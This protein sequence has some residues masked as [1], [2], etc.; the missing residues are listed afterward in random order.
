MT[1]GSRCFRIAVPDTRLL[2]V[3]VT[4]VHSENDAGEICRSTEPFGSDLDI[5]R[6]PF[7]GGV[8]QRD[9]SDFWVGGIIAEDT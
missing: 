3:M 2:L 7:W 5:I 6:K 4:E 1:G 8:P 9:H